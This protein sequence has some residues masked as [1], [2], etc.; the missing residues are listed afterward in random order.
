M[1]S[2]SR[3]TPSALDHAASVF[4]GLR[5]RLFGVAYRMLG[6]AL[7]AEDIVQEVWL[8]WQTTDRTVV[9]DP[10]AFL[11]TATTRLAINLLRSARSRREIYVGPWLPEP[12]DTSADPQ[13]GAERGEALELAVLLLLEK[14]SPTERAA[15]VLREAF[16]YEYSGIAAVL[17]LSEVNAR[18]LVSRARRHIAAGRRDPVDRSEHRRL[19]EAFLVAA[20]TGDLLVLEEVL[21]SDVVSCSDGGGAVGAVRIPVVGRTC[22]A[23]LA[24]FAP[25]FWPGAATTAVDANGRESV[26][27]SHGAASVALL[28]ISTSSRGIDELL[29]VM[30]PAELAGISVG[31]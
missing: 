23:G 27:V 31:R 7:E 13:I 21:A 8:R 10:P 28:S 5:P 1:D 29:W 14:L 3:E 24:A 6:S 18:Q 26:L 25:R 11:V 15:Y 19:L 17:E 30:N 22:V 20:Q 4:V 16:G 9:V 12:V 2:G